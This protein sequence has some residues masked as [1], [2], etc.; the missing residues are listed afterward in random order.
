MGVGVSSTS[1]ERA[2]AVM[3][4]VR[5]VPGSLKA[6]W[7]AVTHR[8]PVHLGTKETAVTDALESLSTAP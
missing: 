4:R 1:V 8:E 5:E 7:D 2:K 6:A 3:Y